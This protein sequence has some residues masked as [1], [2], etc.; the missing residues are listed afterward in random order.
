MENLQIKSIDEYEQ[1]IFDQIHQKTTSEIH[2]QQAAQLEDLKNEIESL[3][4]QMESSDSAKERASLKRKLESRQEKLSDLARKITILQQS[5]DQEEEKDYEAQIKQGKRIPLPDTGRLRNEVQGDAQ[6][7]SGESSEEG[8]DDENVS[9]LQAFDNEAA[10]PEVDD[11]ILENYLQRIA[12]LQEEKDECKYLDSS[13]GV[14]Y[15]IY[16]RLLHYQKTGV[17]WLYTLWKERVG[18]ILADEMGLGKTIQIV[19][20][21]AGLFSSQ[22]LEAPIL[23]VVPL[24]LMKQWM[25]EFHKWFPRVKVKICHSQHFS[26]GNSGLGREYFREPCIIITSY[27]FLSGNLKAFILHDWT[28]VILDEGHKIRNPHTSIAEACKQL[29]CRNR[30]VASGTPIQN[31]LTELWSLFDFVFPGRLGSL[32]TFDLEFCQPIKMGGYSHASSFQVE[33]AFR[34]SCAL[35]KLI[36]PYMLRRIKADVAK[37]LPKKQ[38]H[39]LF[40]K[41]TEA[42][43]QAYISFLNSRDFGMILEGKKMVLSGIDH[44]R[45]IC[46]HLS[47]LYGGGESSMHPPEESSGKMN[48]LSKILAEWQGKHKVLLFCQTRQMLTL[49]QKELPKWISYL[50]MDGTT[51]AKER[52]NLIE[53]FNSD[54]NIFLFLL[55]TKVGGL[56]I[57]LTGA[58]KVII[59]DPDWN[60]STDAQARERA[61]R[62][63][64]TRPVTVFRLITA[65]T[66]E[67]KIYHR[68]IYK[69][70]LTNKI[71][72]DPRQN[73]L[74]KASD[75][76]DL[77]SFSEAEQTETGELFIKEPQ[78]EQ[79]QE[80]EKKDNLLG[81]ILQVAGGI[82]SVFD[83]ERHVDGK[84]NSDNPITLKL[85]AEKIANSAVNALKREHLSKVLQIKNNASS[86]SLLSSLKHAQQESNTN[87]RASLLLSKLIDFMKLNKGMAKSDQL[88]QRF[89]GMNVEPHVFKVLL[90]K[91]AILDK[92]TG[93]WRM[94]KE[95]E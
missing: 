36:A 72:Q 55:T 49:V 32:A 34:C 60:P 6:C 64:Q 54:P 46:N 25:D 76:Y 7:L 1:T 90:Q 77:F 61:W 35:K 68:Q 28:S 15:S 95:F 57:N 79:E 73:A 11:S 8:E 24:T 53:T 4:L 75:L 56:G 58:D 30:I 42:Q 45:K 63:G 44:L 10:I 71:L 94:K 81:S 26:N 62:L 16:S 78:V 5:G 47:L 80:G 41:L 21:A 40:C 23:I 92:S 74:F 51:A 85:E 29:K 89:E 93:V 86:A 69:Q 17:K 87:G 50:R 2:Q 59:F 3:E 83:H 52:S 9:N 14:P 66:I 22:S 19:A 84:M 65:G 48:V 33:T 82:H 31:N 27:S 18:G 39:I 91:I 88:I 70:F 13:F 38:E 67:E 43:R 12:S 37:D 20:F